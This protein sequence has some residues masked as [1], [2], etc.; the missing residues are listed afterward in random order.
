VRN[1]P[2]KGCAFELYRCDLCLGKRP[3]GQSAMTSMACVALILAASL[4]NGAEPNPPNWPASVSVFSPSD[5]S[6]DIEAK[7][8]AAYA[9]NGGHVPAANNGQFSDDRF[10]FLFKPGSYSSDV[11]VGFYTQVLGLGP[12]P[13]DTVF[14]GT[15]GVYCEE[16]D[17][18][19]TVGALDTFWRGAENFK[20][21]ATFQWAGMAKG[22]M[23]WAVSQAAPL[24]RVHVTNE[25]QLYEYQPP[26]PAAGFS[27]GGFLA[28]SQ[29]EGATYAGSQQQWLTRNS[30]L[31]EWK[32]GVWNMVFVGCKGTGLP[33]D[34]CGIYP[35][36]P[37][38]T[39]APTPPPAPTPAPTTCPACTT[40][41]CGKAK[42]GSANPYACINGTATGGCSADA[43][44]WPKPNSGCS[45][46]CDAR[47]CA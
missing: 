29:V 47:C 24:R 15:K 19:F 42:C 17:Y 1:G 14:T 31:G 7:V 38:P 4:V 30:N 22:G 10:A 41:E 36:P 11:P 20:T 8:N 21:T 28:N 5:S 12:S 33:P 35:S 13:D 32:N 40:A 39:P 18:D 6:A 46:C 2:A 27:S 45:S 34:H 37:A 43:K 25:L 23:L 9:K 44:A 26:A 3:L 16:G